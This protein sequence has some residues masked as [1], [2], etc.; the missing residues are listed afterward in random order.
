ME[1]I[2]IILPYITTSQECIFVLMFRIMI[3]PPFVMLNAFQN[4]MI[5]TK[6]ILDFDR[7]LRIWI[8]DFEK[9]ILNPQNG[10][11][12][13]DFG[14]SD[15]KEEILRILEKDFENPRPMDFAQPCSLC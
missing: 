8:L 14:F 11:I 15:F 6:R 5:L 12:L 7:I 3:K 10:R 2:V 1:I 9:R 4:Y 13:R